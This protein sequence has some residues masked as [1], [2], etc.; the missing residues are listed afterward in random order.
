MFRRAER[1]VLIVACTNRAG[2]PR[3][4]TEPWRAGRCVI[5]APFR[6]LGRPVVNTTIFM[7]VYI[8][9]KSKNVAVSLDC[10]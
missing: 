8:L 6:D 3:Q 9:G 5:P 2:I 10:G 1:S 4:R 7:C